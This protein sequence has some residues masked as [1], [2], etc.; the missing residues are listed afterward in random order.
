MK[1][2]MAIALLALSTMAL[3]AFADDVKSTGCDSFKWDVSRELAVLATKPIAIHAGDGKAG[4]TPKLK[5]DTRYTVRLHP[6]HAVALA[7]PAGK[8]RSSDGAQAGLLEF[9][10]PSEGRYTVSLS[11]GH[12]IDVV[13]GGTAIKSLRFQGHL[14]CAV[15]HKIVEFQL[16]AGHD[17]TLQ[18]SGAD[19]NDVVV[20]ITGPL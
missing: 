2:T 6:Q 8:K 16:P 20:A 15:V 18:L 5:A 12:W 13:D 7:V 4:A 14:N 9:R 11:T 19:A 10:A 3:P 1:N 17:L